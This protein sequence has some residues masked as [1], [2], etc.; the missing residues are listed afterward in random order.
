MEYQ[1]YPALEFPFKVRTEKG[2]FT[3]LLV[4]K[5]MGVAEQNLLKAF[6]SAL[7]YD[8]SSHDLVD[9]SN[10]FLNHD[11]TNGVYRK[12]E[13]DVTGMCNVSFNK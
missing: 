5:G 10:T 12:M 7:Q 2:L 1:S 13:M 4:S 3:E 8:T 11:K 9:S 6:F